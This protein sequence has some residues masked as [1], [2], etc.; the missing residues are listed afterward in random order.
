M[1]NLWKCQKTNI[2]FLI[3][4]ILIPIVARAQGPVSAQSAE[5]SAKRERADLMNRLLTEVNPSRE[6]NAYFPPLVKE[7]LAWILSRQAAKTLNLRVWITTPVSVSDN[8][9]M[10]SRYVER[11]Q[12][13]IDVFASAV[14]NYA[15]NKNTNPQA[16]RLW[17]ALSLTHEAAHLENPAT[18]WNRITN[19]AHLMAEEEMRVYRKV[20]LE[21]VRPLRRRGFSVEST[22]TKIDDFLLRCK[23]AVAC[24]ELQEYLRKQGGTPSIAR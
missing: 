3:L 12:P 10:T 4:F 9:V 7:K 13:T 21:A 19:D 11:G 17:F 5:P 18:A 23:D 6:D 2:V 8:S 20:D 22:L 14:F 16:V 24:I 15:K 1:S